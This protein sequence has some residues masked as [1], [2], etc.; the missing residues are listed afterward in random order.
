MSYFP[1]QVRP[2]A[3]GDR[4]GKVEKLHVLARYSGAEVLQLF[5]RLT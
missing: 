3:L 5:L 2:E 4:A 1:R